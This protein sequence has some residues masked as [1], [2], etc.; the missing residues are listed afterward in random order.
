M[1][2]AQWSKTPLIVEVKRDSRE[3]GPGIRSVVFFKG[4]PLRCLFCQN[5]ETQSPDLEI[6]FSEREC[7][8]CGKCAEACPQ[9]AIDLQ[10]PARLRRERCTLCGRCAEVCPGKGLRI[11]GIYYSPEAL[12]EILLRDFSFYKHSGGGVTLSGGECTLYSDYLEC[13]LKL[14]KA[15]GV[16]IVLETSGY[17]DF[18]SFERK[19]LP[20]LDLVYFDIKFADP[21]LHIE[22]TGRSN[23]P[24]LENFWCLLKSGKVSV[25]PRIPIIPGITA[26]KANLASIVDFLCGVGAE[27]V[28]L[29]PYN[30]MGLDMYSSLGR[31]APPLPKRFMRPEEEEEIC[32]LFESILAAKKA[33]APD[34]A[35]PQQTYQNK[36]ARNA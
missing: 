30:P 23:H 34:L 14:L 16:H 24:I 29:L 7:I 36:G 8:R 11:I 25:Q 18:N 28:S 17:F 3:D 35:S 31:A 5:P 27:S 15:N 9:G 26:T 19:I 13:L 1:T 12:T 32:R 20:Y 4:C 6:A 10:G 21:R 33:Q 22:H 2:M